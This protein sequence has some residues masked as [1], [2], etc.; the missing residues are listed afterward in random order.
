MWQTD[1][2][3][4]DGQQKRGCSVFETKMSR[5]N[6]SASTHSL[7]IPLFCYL[8]P[9]LHLHKVEEAK[10]FFFVCVCVKKKTRKK[11]ER[12]QKSSYSSEFSWKPLCN[13]FHSIFFFH[14]FLFFLGSVPERLM[15]RGATRVVISMHTCIDILLSVQYL[16]CMHCVTKIE[17]WKKVLCKTAC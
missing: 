16:F 11:E 5:G 1:D 7:H 14:F 13:S 4:N 8:F 9:F 6:K 10:S 3:Q 12:K 17:F 15:S 2:E